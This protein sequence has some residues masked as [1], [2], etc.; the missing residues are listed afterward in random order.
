[1]RRR[2]PSGLDLRRRRGDAAGVAYDADLANRVRERFAAYDA[3]SE[4]AMF[5]GLSF[6]VNGHLAVAVRSRGGLL[7]RVGEEAVDDAL[8]LP[9][10]AAAVMGAREMRGWI[11]VEPD[12]LSDEERLREWVARGAAHALTKQ[13]KR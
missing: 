4:V 5:G 6:L 10:T 13:P 2:P 9:H 8:A 1:M 3:V 7:V 11:V 12:G